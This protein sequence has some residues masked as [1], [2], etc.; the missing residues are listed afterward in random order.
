LRLIWR[1]ARCYT[2]RG[3]TLFPLL[4]EKRK[5]LAHAGYMT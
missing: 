3:A 4:S 2:Y 1:L 5:S